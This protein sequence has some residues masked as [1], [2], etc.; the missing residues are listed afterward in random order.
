VLAPHVLALPG[1]GIVEVEAF[2]PHFGARMERQLSRSM[3]R[4]DAGWRR[5]RSTGAPGSA[6]ATEISTFERFGKPLTTGDGSVRVIA[7]PRGA[8]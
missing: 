4:N 7:A 5:A 6:S 3:M 1:G 8:V 2:L